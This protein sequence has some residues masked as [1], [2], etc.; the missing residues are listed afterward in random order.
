MFGIGNVH[1]LSAR[2]IAEFFLDVLNKRNT[3]SFAFEQYKLESIEYISSISLIV[4][5]AQI[6]SSNIKKGHTNQT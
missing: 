2:Q 3:F 6:F 1:F 5:S 4:V